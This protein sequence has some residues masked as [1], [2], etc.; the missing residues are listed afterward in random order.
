LDSAL[1][2]LPPSKARALLKR[3]PTIGDPA[4]D[5]ILLFAGIAPLP[6]LESNGLRV[7]ARLGLFVEGRSYDQSYKAGTAVLKAQGPADFDGL[8]RAYLM[9][10]EHGKTLCRRSTPECGPCPL[11]DSCPRAVVSF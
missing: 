10:R 9:L 8:R 6:A 5:K 2:A 1:R 7:L 3:F 11:S 4:T